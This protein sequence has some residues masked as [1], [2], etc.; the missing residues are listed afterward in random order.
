ML[1]GKRLIRANRVDKFAEDPLTSR[2][3]KKGVNM[4][5]TQLKI[6]RRLGE[7][8]L[9]ITEPKLLDP[10]C[11][12][13]MEDALLRVV[14]TGKYNKILLNFSNVTFLSS[15]FLGCLVNMLKRIRE[16][17]G[18][19]TLCKIDPELFRVFQIT[20]LDKVFDII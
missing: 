15:R 20:R 12:R 4:E 10:D 9:T 5:Q 17:K 18:E 7:I 2:P 14:D 1:N 16:N 8:M 3:C 13:E 19:L 6:E 11:I